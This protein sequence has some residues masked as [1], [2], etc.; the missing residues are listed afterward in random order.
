MSATTAAVPVRVLGVEVLDELRGV[1][2]DP[3]TMFFSVAMPVGFYALFVT[4][5][6]SGQ[7]GGLP[8]ATS[9][10]ASF[11]AYGA[12]A[13]TL[14]NPGIGVAEDRSRGWLRVKKA[15][16]VPVATTLL[17][18]VLATLP[19]ALAVLVAMTGVWMV[20]ASG[21]LDAPTWVRLVA[22]LVAGA[23]PFALV[24]LAVGF[25]AS[26]N[27]TPA[28]LHAVLIPSAVAS[29]LWMPLEFLPAPIQAVA[30]FLPTYHLAQ[31]ALAQ[32]TG[33]G[34]LDHALALLLTTIAAAALAGLAYR[35]LRV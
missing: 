4:M 11:G 3:A 14:L 9:M 15:S 26:A 12:V 1:V 30:P 33:A 23:L 22:V 28:I 34:M 27:A 16:A 19:Y 7:I 6:G 24:G 17:A 35:K 29:G 20:T 10:L 18:K 13:V 25:V 8:V 32:L 21:G 31:L 2:R 5:F